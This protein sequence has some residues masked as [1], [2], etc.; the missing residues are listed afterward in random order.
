[1]EVGKMEKTRKEQISFVKEWIA[2]HGS[3][4][5]LEKLL[6]GMEHE[7]VLR[8]Q[9]IPDEI[10]HEIWGSNVSAIPSDKV[11][12]LQAVV[13]EYDWPSLRERGVNVLKCGQPDPCGV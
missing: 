8:Y 10:F 6:H 12:R 9:F 11:P 13:P 7:G 4:A 5:D 3:T 1:M 2:A